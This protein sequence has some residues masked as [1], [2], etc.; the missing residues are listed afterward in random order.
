MARDYHSRMQLLGMRALVCG[1]TQGIGLASA[2]A[3][4]EAGASVVLMA[5]DP[6]RLREVRGELPSPGGQEHAHL[7]ADFAQPDEVRGV[8]TEYV[9]RAGPVHILVNNTGGPPGG[10]IAAA[11]PEEF[12]AA[13]ASHLLCNH[14]LAQAVLP[15]MRTAGYG[16]IV[17]IVSTSVRQPI[18]GLGVSNTIRGAVASWAKTLA[19]EVARDGITVNNVLPG[20]TRT[21]RLEGL[22]EQRARASG[23]PPSDIEAEFLAEIPMGRFAE[24]A[25]IAAAVLFLASP[26]AGYITGVSLAVDGGRT[27][28]L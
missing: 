1:S 3:L 7:A 14:H 19:G 8:A 27:Q 28:A 24:P 17:N 9:R 15:G 21:A 2:V 12:E 13:F 25:E 16:R 23:R 11:R 20:A 10:P 6:A 18:R 26:A 22:F 4:A 5:R